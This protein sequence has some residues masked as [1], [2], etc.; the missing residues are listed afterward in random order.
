[1]PVSTTPLGPTG[2]G[3]GIK[4]ASTFLEDIPEPTTLPSRQ[5]QIMRFEA[6]VSDPKAVSAALV[7]EFGE[8]NVNDNGNVGIIKLQ[9]AVPSE[10]FSTAVKSVGTR[11]GVEG[12]SAN[13]ELN[14][15]LDKTYRDIAALEGER[16][17]LEARLETETD[18]Q[19]LEFGRLTLENLEAQAEQQ[20]DAYQKMLEQLETGVI[21]VTLMPEPAQ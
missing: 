13:S 14:G 11:L 20:Q 17:S 6:T 5:Q 12:T 21:H 7:A 4:T 3:S 1:V 8:E 2:Q 16:A 15:D 18:P 19:T 10:A 9:I